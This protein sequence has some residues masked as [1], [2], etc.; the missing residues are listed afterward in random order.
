[1]FDFVFVCFVLFC[2]VSAY[3]CVSMSLRSVVVVPGWL[4]GW[5]AGWL[6]RSDACDNLLPHGS[7]HA[8]DA[9]NLF[10]GVYQPSAHG[11]RFG[12]LWS[13]DTDV[14]LHNP[15]S[16]RLALSLAVYDTPVPGATAAASTA[17]SS[18]CATSAA[19]TPKKEKNKEPGPEG[20]GEGE[21]DE[22]PRITSGFSG[23]GGGGAKGKGCGSTSSNS[24]KNNSERLH[25]LHWWRRAMP[26]A[27]AAGPV[28]CSHGP[29][30]AP[31]ALLAAPSAVVIPEALFTQAAV[32]APPSSI[33]EAN[34]SGGSCD[35]GGGGALSSGSVAH[36]GAL[37]RG[38]SDCEERQAPTESRKH[39]DDDVKD[40]GSCDSDSDGDGDGDDSSGDSDDSE[41]AHVFAPG[42]RA[43]AFATHPTSF[44]RR[45]RRRGG[46]HTSVDVDV[47]AIGHGSGA[48]AGAAHAGASAGVGPTISPSRVAHD[49]KS[50]HGASLAGGSRA[51]HASRPAINTAARAHPR[52][53]RRASSRKRSE[54]APL[55][56]SGTNMSVQ[57]SACVCVGVPVLVCVC[58][59]VCVCLCL[60]YVGL[61]DLCV[62][63]IL[64]LTCVFD[65]R[66]VPPSRWHVYVGVG[67][68]V[69]AAE[70]RVDLLSRMRPTLPC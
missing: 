1:M 45:R 40:A 69:Q 64:L 9:M 68:A 33:P 43:S 34:G 7:M 62:G 48:G 18:V 31:G 19:S 30:L 38:R 44:R 47:N 6:R 54:T 52:W 36:A 10:L 3:A 57:A 50:R 35:G 16:T 32:V 13:L 23:G 25:P 49:S 39:A 5:R 37:E 46:I 65:V 41:D 58:V 53:G 22:S 51:Q 59:S 14:Y 2:F 12:P 8:Q 21:G 4:A 17:S 70:A 20:E 60:V 27:G 61:C 26:S 63:A 55:V 42:A 66:L 56:V 24:R 67:V 11:P 29:V 28:A 15:S